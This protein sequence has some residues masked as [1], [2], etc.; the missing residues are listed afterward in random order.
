[1]L[2][3][4]DANREKRRKERNDQSHPR[5]LPE[6]NLHA[7]AGL[8]QHDQVGHGTQRSGVAGERACAGYNEPDEM[9]VGK[10][11]HQRAE[12]QNGRNIAHKV[13]KDQHDAAHREQLRREAA[14][15]SMMEARDQVIDGARRL[16]AVNDDKERGEKQ[17]QLPIEAL[18]DILRPSRAQSPA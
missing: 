10:R 18:V 7:F 11:R 12:K 16:K 3:R 6:R 4:E 15:E 13:R 5:E 8:L 9:T 14:F 2:Q 1:M 17:Q